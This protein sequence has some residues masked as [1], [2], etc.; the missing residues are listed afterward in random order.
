MQERK[1]SDGIW[2]TVAKPRQSDE[3][4]ETTREQGFNQHKRQDSTSAHK[5]TSIKINQ[6]V[7]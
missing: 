7:S 1:K 4:Q 5:Q 2:P 3:Q 6:Q